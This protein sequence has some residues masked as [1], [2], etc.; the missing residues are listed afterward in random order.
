MRTPTLALAALVAA[1]LASGLAIPRHVT[2]QDRPMP[3]TEFDDWPVLELDFP[4]LHIG[5][6]EYREGPTGTT[7][8]Y[9][10]GRI[11]A[12]VDVRGGS[13]GSIETDVIRMGYEHKFV[14]AIAFAGGSAYGLAASTG[15]A[16]AIKETRD[17]PTAWQEIAVVPGAIIFDLGDRRF[18]A[19]T[20]DAALGAAALRS[21]RPGRFPLGA[22]GAGRFAMQGSFFGGRSYSGQ[23]GA[24]RESG[25]TKIAVFTVVNARGTVVDR[26]GNVVR[27]SN[28]PRVGCGSADEM[29]A[30][31]VAGRTGA[32]EGVGGS[33]SGEGGRQNTTISIVVTNQR[34]EAWQLDRLA[35][36]VHTSMGRAIRPFHS[37]FDGDILFAV[38]TNEVD[39]PSLALGDLGALASDAAWDA[40]VS[41]VPE[42]DDFSLEVTERDPDEYDVLAGVYDFGTGAQLTIR[43]EGASLIAE[44]TGSKDVY[45]FELG[46]PRFLS[47]LPGT[48]HMD[49]AALDPTL[50][51][52]RF[53]GSGDDAELILNPG[54]WAQAAR[55]IP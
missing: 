28:D 27:C 24:F 15:V 23:G 42:L 25:P 50:E 13:P 39:N 2:A 55:R 49:F 16:E 5:I 29:I 20:P 19:V 31:A 10:P 17:D 7:V 44:A 8:F 1:P 26:D 35:V 53:S 45:G 46:T 32:G 11:T 47:P 51:R 3:I 40:V 12:A 52:V 22:R 4:S 18:N 21:A 48:E 41:S 38:S 30:A 43:R 37:E 14:D 9:F 34:L 36:Q 6:A 54:H 33:D